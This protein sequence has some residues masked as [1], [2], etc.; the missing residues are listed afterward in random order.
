[1]NLERYEI[2]KRHMPEEA[3][4]VIAEAFPPADQLITKDYLDA[5]FAEFGAQIRAEINNRFDGINGRMLTMMVSLV[6]AQ[7]V[8][9]A[10]IIVAILLK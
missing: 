4:R 8:G 7:F 2:L 3:A 9:V 5:R 10:G 1:M 6:A